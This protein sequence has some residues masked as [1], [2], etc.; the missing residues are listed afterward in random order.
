MRSNVE[1]NAVTGT[2]KMKAKES[3]KEEIELW[4]RREINLEDVE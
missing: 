3:E 1:E 2:G 4:G